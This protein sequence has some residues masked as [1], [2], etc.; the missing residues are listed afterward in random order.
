MAVKARARVAPSLAAAALSAWLLSV[1]VVQQP[2]AAALQVVE[3]PP[4]ASAAHA[5]GM[6]AISDDC[7]ACHNGLRTQEGEDVSIGIAWRA[8]IMANSSR[9]PYWQAGVRREVMDHPAAAQAIE[10]ECAICHMPMSRTKA[11]AA[12]HEGR[13]FAHL[14][15]GAPATEDAR[16]AA[17]GVS[18]TLCH[19]I[20]PE[21]LGTRESFT[22]GFVISPPAPGG[23]RR[24]FGPFAIDAG[25]THVMRSATGM[26]PAE[27]AHI[28][29]SELC[30]TCHTLYTQAIG[31]KGEV[32]GELPEQVPYLEWRHSAFR[33]ERSC[34]SCHMPAV[35]APTPI[36][37]VLGVGR[38]GLARHTFLGGNFFMLRMLNRYRG[39]LGVAALPQELDAAAHATIAQLEQDTATVSVV[40][41]ESIG[42]RLEVDVQVQN[43]TG[44]KLPTAYPSRRA[45][46]HLTVRDRDDDT[47][48]SSGA[49]EPTGLI[50]GNDNDT[51][52]TRVEP[53]HTEI[54]TEHE[55]Q[56]YESVM[57][58]VNGRITTGLL[59]GTGYTKDN[60]LLPRGFDKATAAPD[61]AVMGAARD[62]ENFTDGSDRVRYSVDTAGREGPFRVEV[63][64][65]YQPI[66]FRW[67][68]NLKAYDAIETRRFVTWFDAMSS[69]SSTV[70]AQTTVSEA[71]SR[72]VARNRRSCADR[73]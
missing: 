42:D 2:T 9:D 36:S 16:L 43:M 19:Q 17:D 41:A 12:G 62:D 6:F 53:H 24:M 45:W 22:G 13:I 4:P 71:G 14:P 46:L 56:I 40:R 32:L 72:R 18:C 37:S 26:M 67:A 57:H 25:R 49:I 55:V 38:E 3:P 52:P 8:S 39:E 61:I 60:R 27:A 34:Q 33:E 15:I 35:A 10:D 20:G 21:R 5:N 1:L 69:G 54:R 70:L 65:R 47:F 68:Q 31:P 29:A 7:L 48:F 66:S 64:L 30:A 11:S 73:H 28:R 58:D 59:Q 63:I 23:E 44:H 51:D 50:Q